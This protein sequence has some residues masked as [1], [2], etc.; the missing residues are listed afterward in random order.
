MSQ[1]SPFS[2][3]EYSFPRGSPFSFEEYFVEEY[4]QT[5]R[6]I[7]IHQEFSIEEYNYNV[8]TESEGCATQTPQIIEGHAKADIPTPMQI[9]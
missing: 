7:D 6:N 2:V 9:H 8:D 4:S 5:P 3:E 1:N